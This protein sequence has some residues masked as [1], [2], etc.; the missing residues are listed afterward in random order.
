MFTQIGDYVSIKYVLGR[1]P[2]IL[3]CPI[4]PLQPVVTM[5]LA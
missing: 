3:G 4:F 2:A 5:L 1:L